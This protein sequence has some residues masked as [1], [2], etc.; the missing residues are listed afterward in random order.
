[1]G[2][3][4]MDPPMPPEPDD[5]L[6]V[7]DLTNGEKKIWSIPCFYFNIEKPLDYHDYHEH[8]H[9]GWPG[10]D[11]P[12]MSCQNPQWWKD[13]PFVSN[14]YNYIDMSEA[15]KI[16]LLSEYEGYVNQLEYN[17]QYYLPVSIEFDTVDRDGNPVSTAGIEANG[18]IRNAPEDHII[19]LDFGVNISKFVGDPKEFIF[20]AYLIRYVQIGGGEPSIDD[21][22]LITR[23]KLVVLPG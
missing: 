21:K 8:D 16:H 6:P 3:R 19:D 10:P 11:K 22:T 1:M 4:T 9:R 14:I 12:D 17:H 18:Y 7:F 20:N 15:V 5:V 2:Y 13:Y 23:G